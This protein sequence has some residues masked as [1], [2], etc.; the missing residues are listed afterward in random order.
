MKKHIWPIAVCTAIWNLITSLF[1]VRAPGIYG[2]GKS[3]L[4]RG[5]I[6][7]NVIVGGNPE[8][9]VSARLGY[10]S[11]RHHKNKKDDGF[12]W[13]CESIVDSTFE[14]I[15]GTGHCY[16]AFRWTETV[17][18]IRKGQNLHINHGPDFMLVALLFLVVTSCL[19]IYPVNLLIARF[20]SPA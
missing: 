8:V 14:P 19:I 4:L 15:D 5:D 12:W 16:S 1:G 2:Y 3:V 13:L 18:K 10:Q 9:T 11:Y 7:G 20:N 17:F 6:L